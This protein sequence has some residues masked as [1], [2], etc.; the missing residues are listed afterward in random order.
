MPS[1]PHPA[2]M[3][4]WHWLLLAAIAAVGAWLLYANAPLRWALGGFC[5]LLA[6]GSFFGRRYFERLKEERKNE[7]ICTFARSLPARKHDTW[8]VRAVYE[9]LTRLVRVP[10]RPAD[11][12]SR[13]L[14]LHPDD[15]D[16]AA[17]VIAQRAGRSMDDPQK[18]PLFDRVRTVADMVE[19]FEH[20][21]K[22]PNQ[23]LEPT[24][25]LVTDRAGARSAPSKGV[26]HL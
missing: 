16:D 2:K 22:E 26:A 17:F 12:L 20:Q 7:S 8:V 6:I 1:R 4:I 23:A 24:P 10:V 13:D 11:D 21:K 15:R 25:L 18:N 14:R 5:V 9:E 19:F 3:T